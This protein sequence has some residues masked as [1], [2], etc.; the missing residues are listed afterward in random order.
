MGRLI[1]QGLS[2]A[3]VRAV[4]DVLNFH[5]RR[6]AALKVDGIFGPMTHARVIEFQK[7]NQLKPDGIVGP[8]TMLKLFEE[9]QMP[10]RLA[11]QP[12]AAAAPRRN[13][14]QPPRL[15]PPLPI[16]FIL[17]PA[18]SVGIPVLTPAGQ[19]LTFLLTTPVRNDPVDPAMASF[20]QIMRLLNQLPQNFP[21]RGAIL[22]AVPKPVKKIG[23]LELDPVKPMNFGF[24]WGVDPVF[25]L[26]SLGPPINFLVGV[27]ADA[28]YVLKLVD[29]PGVLVPQLGLFVQGDFKGTIDWTSKSAESRPQIDLKGA[30]SAGIQGTF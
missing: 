25:D 1:K 27:K 30:I 6:L 10:I 26:K 16:P 19:T 15:L 28:R 14:I 4:Q 9:E 7:S 8:N 17:P 5:I 3:D 13:A 24:Q 11:L 21:F 23:P 29:K 18:S 22:G 2:G 20:L 12:Q